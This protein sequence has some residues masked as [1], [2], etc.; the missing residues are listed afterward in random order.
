MTA[1]LE[2]SKLYKY[3]VANLRSL[4]I[5]LKKSAISA[6]TA[7]SETDK[8]AVESFTR[9]FAFLLGAWAETRLHKLIN[10]NSAFSDE[11]KTKIYSQGSQLE[12]WLKTVEISFRE[13]YQVPR[14]DLNHTTLPHTAFHRFNT[15]YSIIN[16]DLK[17]VIEVRNRLA[18]GQ[19]IYPLNSDC[20]DVEQEKYT[21]INNENLLSL[22]FKK[23]LITTVADVIHDLVVSQPTFERDF[24]MHY[25]SII[26]TKTNLAN[27]D[28]NK[29]IVGLIAKRN[30]G[31]EKRRNREK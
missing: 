5:A 7:I 16:D 23:S 11:N 18:H 29:Y 19:W 22:Q 1:Y 6:R 4:E 24:D 2:Q 13:Y 20:T 25:K 8:P 3:H 14:A 15:I 26:S 12:Q 28:Y 17:S 27:R 21:L 9:L 30:R 10:E 31:I